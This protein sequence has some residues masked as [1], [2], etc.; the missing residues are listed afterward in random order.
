[1]TGIH[2][3][4]NGNAVAG[5]NVRKV[6]AV[7]AA[8]SDGTSGQIFD[9]TVSIQ[10]WNAGNNSL[11]VTSNGF[12][13]TIQVQA[14]EANVGTANTVLKSISAVYSGGRV[15]TGIY[16]RFDG[17]TVKG[18]YA[19]GSVKELNGYT[20]SGNMIK[21][22][23]NT[24]TVQYE[25]KTA[26]FSVTGYQQATISIHTTDV[27]TITVAQD[28]S[29]LYS[30]LNSTIPNRNGY[31]FEG[32][33]LDKECTQNISEQSRVLDGMHVFAKWKQVGNWKLNKSK[34]V[35]NKGKTMKLSIKGQKSDQI[36][37]KTSKKK[38]AS[39][40]KKGVVK[41]KKAGKA[42][43]TAV[44]GDGSVLT[45]NVTVKKVKKKK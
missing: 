3:A 19:D 11:V 42:V 14:S 10:S 40:S 41:G 33:F 32:W 43:I 7:N 4:V 15:P 28:D 13:K 30:I 27:Q 25:G 38:V 39:V 35:I 45:C 5:E 21:S 8:Y 20:L 17:L 16:Y 44:T 2:V 37:W 24:V 6:L 1:M 36:R 9:Y 18:V 26:V 31:Q 22:G 23:N 29:S 12:S 34:A